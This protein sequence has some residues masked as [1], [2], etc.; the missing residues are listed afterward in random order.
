VNGEFLISLL[1]VG[2]SW[3]KVMRGPLVVF[4]FLLVFAGGVLC[5]YIW[6]EREVL[7]LEQKVGWLEIQQEEGRQREEALAAQLE[8]LQQ[9]HEVVVKEARR[10]QQDIGARLSRLEGLTSGLAQ[11]PRQDRESS[12]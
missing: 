9:V 6:Q 7:L 8:E 5:G 12:E 4:S 2:V 10:L 11:E 3:Y 1:R